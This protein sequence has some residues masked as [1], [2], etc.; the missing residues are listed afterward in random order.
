MRWSIFNSEV[1]TWS[2]PSVCSHCKPKYPTLDSFYPYVT[3]ILFHD[4]VNSRETHQIGSF[5]IKSGLIFYLCYDLVLWHQNATCLNGSATPPLCTGPLRYFTMKHMKDSGEGSSPGRDDSGGLFG[6]QTT[7]QAKHAIVCL[8]ISRWLP[9]TSMT[10]QVTWP[11]T[12][13]PAVRCRSP[14]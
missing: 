2:W 6:K 9:T 10:F 3:Q 7:V 5:L 8:R 11:Q 14:F 1:G 4:G 13:H 12:L